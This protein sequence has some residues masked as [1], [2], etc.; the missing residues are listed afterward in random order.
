MDEINLYTY[1]YDRRRRQLNDQELDSGDDE[2]RN[3]RAQSEPQVEE[4][5]RQLTYEAGEIDRKPIPEPS[6]GEACI[7]V[8]LQLL[9]I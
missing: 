6:D 4:Q 5:E 2:G 8:E 7:S 1:G 9:S 3:D